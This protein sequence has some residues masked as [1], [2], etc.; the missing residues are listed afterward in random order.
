MSLHLELDTK[1]KYTVDELVEK[2]SEPETIDDY[3]CRKCKKETKHIKRSYIY[4]LPKILLVHI[5]RFEIGY[6]SAK[7]LTT[8]IELD[9]ELKIST[10]DGTKNSL[11][12]LS[13]V[14]HQGNMNY[15]HYY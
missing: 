11:N 12:L 7:K 15:G 5:K 3:K 1:K 8:T 10:Y 14:H 6:Y 13:I 9:N 4:S 2:L